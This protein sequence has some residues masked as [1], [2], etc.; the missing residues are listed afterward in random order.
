MTT[1]FY[2]VLPASRASFQ[3]NLQAPD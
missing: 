1:S 2:A 3:K